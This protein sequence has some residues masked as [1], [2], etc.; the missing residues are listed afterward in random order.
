MLTL[1]RECRVPLLMVVTMRGEAG[2][3]NPWQV[4]MGRI[5]GDA[6]RLAHAGGA[7]SE[8][9]RAVARQPVIR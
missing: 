9:V 4:H 5:A 7:L 8:T 3:T 1:A 2:E 6:L